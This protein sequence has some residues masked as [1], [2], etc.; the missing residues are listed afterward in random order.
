MKKFFI[1]SDID[2]IIKRTQEILGRFSNKHIVLTGGRGF[3]GRYLTEIFFRYNKILNKPIK[4]TVIDN[5]AVSSE[6]GDV[7]PNYNNFK[8]IKSDVSKKIDLGK[9]SIINKKFLDNKLN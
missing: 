6:L 7:W 9:S 2:E 4:L 1:D 5:F 3:L 8:F